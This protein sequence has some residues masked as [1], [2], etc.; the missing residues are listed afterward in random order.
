MTCAESLLI[1]YFGL[2]NIHSEDM[3]DAEEY[4]DD[5]VCCQDE[6]SLVR[7]DFE[8]DLITVRD[9]IGITPLTWGSLGQGILT[10]KYDKNSTFADNDRRRRD[11]YVNF[12]GEKLEKNLNIV[13][14]MKPIAERRDKPVSAIAIRFILDYLRD[15]VVLVGAKRPGQIEGNIKAMD[16]KLNKEELETLDTVSRS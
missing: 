3:K 2:S 11:A 10:G 1:R 12:H 7:R 4:K 16:W 15:S 9:K 13:E 14:A 5:F 6:Y 8:K